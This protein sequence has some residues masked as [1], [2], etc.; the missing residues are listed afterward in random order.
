MLEYFEVKVK[1]NDDHRKWEDIPVLLQT[2]D[3]IAMLESNWNND[4]KEIRYNKVGSLQGH[5][6]DTKKINYFLQ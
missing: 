6:F 1:Y 2:S 4:I 3:I 5:Y